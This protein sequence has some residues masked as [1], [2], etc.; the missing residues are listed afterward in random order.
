M[1]LSNNFIMANRIHMQG[2]K[3][4][5]EFYGMLIDLL[6]ESKVPFMIGGT[7]A[8]TAYTGIERTTKDMDFCCTFEDYPKILRIISEAGDDYDSL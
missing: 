3:R 4:A 1:L 2:N 5:E 7:Y 6:L 8:F